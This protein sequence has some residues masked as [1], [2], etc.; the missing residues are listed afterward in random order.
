MFR[1]WEIS[2]QILGMCGIVNYIS[3]HG[4]NVFVPFI[5]LSKVHMVTICVGKK[6][7]LLLKT[8]KI[9]TACGGFG[10]SILI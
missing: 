5:V 1:D 10:Y 7:K 8:E 2:G 6:N 4:M 9:L 3:L